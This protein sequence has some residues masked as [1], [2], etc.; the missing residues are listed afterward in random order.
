MENQADI[1]AALSEAKVLLK[2]LRLLTTY[3]CNGAAAEANITCTGILTSAVIVGAFGFK[4]P[5]GTGV[6]VTNLTAETT[7]SGA[8]QVM[9]STTDTTGWKILVVCFNK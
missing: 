7:V 5:T 3:V 4:A 8:G 2:E 1:L 9:C 6:L